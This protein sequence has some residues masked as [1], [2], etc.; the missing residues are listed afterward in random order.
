MPAYAQCPV[1]MH[2]GTSVSAASRSISSS[3]STCV[4]AWGWKTGISPWSSVARRAS[5]STLSTNLS[6]S[7]AASGCA[8]PGRPAPRSRSALKPWMITRCT[9]RRRRAARRCAADLQRAGGAVGRVQRLEDV[10]ADELELA[11][12]ELA[13]QRHRIAGEVAERAELGAVVAGVRDVGE[14]PLPARVGAV[15]RVLDAPGGRRV[16]DADLHRRD[17]RNAIAAGAVPNPSIAGA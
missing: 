13:A 6:H 7:S 14:Q 5:R 3:N 9:A 8:A 17:A 16:R 2:S 11:V 1:S 4:P 15:L 10:A 12:G